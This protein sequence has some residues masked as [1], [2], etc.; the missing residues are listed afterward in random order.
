ML[1]AGCGFQGIPFAG[2]SQFSRAGAGEGFVSH[3]QE[4]APEESLLIRE[5][6]KPNWG[7]KFYLWACAGDICG[8]LLLFCSQY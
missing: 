2:N 7:S 1:H 4:T 3:C 8:C 5:E 6:S